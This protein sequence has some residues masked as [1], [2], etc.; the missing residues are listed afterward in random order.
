MKNWRTSNKNAAPE[1]KKT[2]ENY[3]VTVS[4]YTKSA[5]PENKQVLSTSIPTFTKI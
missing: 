1:N 2:G 5:M 3:L 4:N